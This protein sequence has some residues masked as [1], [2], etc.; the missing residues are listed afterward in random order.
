MIKIFVTGG[1]IDDLDYESL[2]DAP[3]DLDSL[4][5]KALT[6]VRLSVEYSTEVVFMKDS[7]HISHDDKE[8]LLRKCKEAVED[9]IIITHGTITMSD[10][11]KMLGLSGIRKTIVLVGATEPINRNGSEAFFNLG[12]AMAAVQLLPV[13]VYV[14]MNGKIFQGDKVRKNTK[15]GY[16]E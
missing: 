8:L 9:K 10:T 7:R 1:T 11:A 15:T 5:E 12:M 2:Q 4:I 6:T 3:D 16:F 14:A 13:G